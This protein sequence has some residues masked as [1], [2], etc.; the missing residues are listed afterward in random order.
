MAKPVTIAQARVV[1]D[2]PHACTDSG[3]VLTVFGAL[4]DTLVKRDAG[5]CYAPLLATSWTISPDARTFTFRLREGVRFHNGDAFDS[6]AVKFSL[7]RMARPDMGATLGAPGVYAQYLAGLNVTCPDAHTVTV[8]LAEPMADLFDVLVAG[9]MVS[10]RAIEAA[11]DDLAARAV[12]TGPYRLESYI[13]GEEIRLAAVPGH[14]DGPVANP[15]LR[16]VRGATRDQRLALF[17]QGAADVAN[18]LET[19][20]QQAL[21]GEAGVTVVDYLAPTAIILMFNAAKGPGADSRVRRAL[22]LGIDREALVRDV[23]DGA[24]QPL[25]GFVSPVHFGA[26]PEAPGFRQDRKEARL[27]LAEAG[28]ASGVTFNIYCP[29]RLPDEAQALVK[30]LEAQLADLGVRF[31]VHLEADRTLYANQVRLKQIHDI[32]VFDSSPMSVFRV[33]YEKVDSRIRGSWWE[34]YANP[35]VEALIDRARRTPD[36]AAREAIF[37]ECYRRLQDDPPW[38]YLYN[39]RRGIALKGA[40]SGWAM[41]RDGV[42]DVR[43]LP[44]LA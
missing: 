3:D 14:F 40:H 35:A 19:A 18:G 43:C 41:R 38:L 32:C 7:E 21:R 12:G 15:S 30:A 26:D 22:N 8:V 27:L 33:L 9:N 31:V 23:L 6:A 16:Y 5:G 4:F 29:T 25:H 10:P 2:D 36:D 20:E 42:L 17:R 24:G 34:G 44:A 1:L 13:A 37:R 11:G 28:H 39:H